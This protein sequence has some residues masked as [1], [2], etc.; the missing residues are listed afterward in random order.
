MKSKVMIA[1]AVYDT[2]ENDRTKFTRQTIDKLF[3]QLI[4]VDNVRIVVV[5]N[6]SCQLTKDTLHYYMLQWMIKNGA[7]NKIK[8]QVITNETNVGT[9]EA[10]NQAWRL[11]EPGEYLIKMDNDCVVNSA[12]CWWDEMVEVLQRDPSIGMVG[13]KRKDCEEKPTAKNEWYKS[14]LY[15]LPQ[16]KGQ[17]WIVVEQVQ[18][19]MGTCHMF[20]PEIIDK[21]GGLWQ[22]GGVYGFD[23]VFASL[24]AS[25][26]GFKTVFLPHI[27][28]EH[29]DDGANPY[30]QEKEA[31]A[32]SMFAKYDEA[33]AQMINGQLSYYFPL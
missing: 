24:R 4:K 31:Y 32:K 13:L 23:D 6:A 17:K 14:M 1:M 25:L 5:D 26:A 16:E 8:F 29:I 11:R 15:M 19:V 30:Q 2:V 10:I 28:I 27:E 21:I 3:D 18:H 12:N 33:K 20:S 22:M 9:A 7:D